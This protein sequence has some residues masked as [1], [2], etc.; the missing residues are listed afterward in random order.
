MDLLRIMS[1][2]NLNRFKLITFDVTGTL[3]QFRR[4]PGKQYNEIGTLYGV[5]S[6]TTI[7]S[8]N[9]KEVWRKMVKEHPNFGKKSGITWE[10]WWEK[11][12]F[13]TYKDMNVEERILN[14][15]TKDLIDYYKTMEAWEQSYGAL[16]LLSYLRNRNIPLGIISNFDERLTTVLQKARL[17]HYFRFVLVSYS[18]DFEKPENG[19]FNLAIKESQIPGLRPEDCLHV[20]DNYALDFV[21]AKNAGWNAILVNESVEKLLQKYPEVKKEEVFKNLGELHKNFQE[22]II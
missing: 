4:S 2:V 14:D 19:I 9:F 13:G 22:K 7:L 15:I 17:R 18:C 20:G 10:K 12:V 11:V 1:K 8:K 5:E 21:G 3:L 16:G 6:D